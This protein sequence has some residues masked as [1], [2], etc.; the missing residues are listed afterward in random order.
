M[1]RTLRFL[2]L[3]ALPLL[4][5]SLLAQGTYWG[6]TSAG[7]TYGI[8]TI[9][10][11][12]E[13]NVYTK[14]YDFFKYDGGS[15]KGEV[16]K[17]SNGLYYGVTEF[18]GTAGV[19]VL[20]SY[21]PSTTAYTVLI[22]FSAATSPSSAAIG[23]RP[24]R[25]LRQAANG[26]LYGTCTQGGVNNLGTLFDFNIGTGV[27]TKRR[28]FDNLTTSLRSGSTPRGRLVQASNGIIYG[29]T[30]QGG[31]NGTGVIFSLSTTNTF[32]RLFDFP[33]LVPGTTGIRPFSGLMQASNGL[34]YGTTQSGGTSSGGVIYSF[35]ITG[36]VYTSVYDFV[37][38]T[39]RFPLA[40][41]VQPSNGLLYGTTTGG[42]VN[43]AGVIFSYDPVGDAY[44]DRTDL[45]SA[46]GYNPLSR[47]IVGSNGLLYGTADLGGTNSAG[48]LYSFNTASNV[49]TQVYEMAN[50]GLSDPWGGLL[51][52][53]AGTLVG[54]SNAGGVGGEG[55][56]YKYVIST[57][58][59]TELVPFSFSNGS[60]PLGR[61]LK[62]SNGLFYGLTQNGGTNNTGIL[63]SFDPTS[64]VF[65][66]LVN[67]ST[68]L[69]TY[70][71]GTMVEVS[72]KL[73]GLCSHGGTADGGTVFEYTIGGSC[74]KKQDL[75]L[76]AAGTVPLNGFFK[77]TSGKLYSTTS[78]GAANALGGL[79]DYVPGTNT[80]TPLHDFTTAD[81]SSPKGDLMQASNGS[82]YGTTSLNGQFTFGSIF[83]WNPSTSTF[84]RLYSFNSAEGAAPAGDLVQASN[85]KLYGTFSQ[86]GQGASGGIFSWNITT[87][88]YTEEYDMNIPP[89][90]TEGKASE[91]SLVQG[92]DGLLYGTCSE[93]G[94]SGTLGILFRFNPTSL[95]LTILT[96]YTGTA[97]GAS[98]FD[99]VVNETLPTSS[100]LLLNAKLFLE[101]PYDSG[102]GKMNSALRLLTG[103]NGFPTTEPFTAAGFTIVGGGGE[104][105]NASVLATTGDNA[106]V[107][108]VLVEL[109]DKN[110]SS[111]ILRTK[112]ALLQSDGDIV[113]VDNA[114]LLTFPLAVDNY[115]VAI[116][117]RNHFGVMTS[118]ATALSGSAATVDFRTGAQA[119]YGTNAQKTVGT[120]KVSWAGNVVRDHS[121]AYTGANND[122]D[123][124]LV[125]VGSTVP[126]NTVTGYY[127][128]DVTLD[129]VVSYT[130]TGNDR[131]PILVNVGGTTPNNTIAEQIP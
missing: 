58:T 105:I 46:I 55:A 11:I 48:V 78:T 122:R 93:G 95:A 112:A 2:P 73:Y 52:D 125:R 126:T 42:G 43:N 33:A 80:L 22:N 8:G 127:A 64:S 67:F 120:A 114:S 94:T 84:T 75:A 98:P 72:G 38:V 130:G 31:T 24:F 44:V 113:D 12:T 9:Y 82:L 76:T 106:V 107:D 104:T 102:T 70:P 99:G 108:W 83:S 14:K 47:M 110:N 13:A 36:S 91:S 85:G 87:S 16:I 119:T 45:S 60:A 3:I 129:G 111:T 19:G 62:S 88:T 90:T 118:T 30:Q 81:G 63:F 26:K 4:P 51:E 20:F 66:R 1:F 37:Q 53:P 96:N 109:R 131:D 65:T 117:Q 74:V 34:L 89:I 17:A 116:R 29:T 57:A 77:A 92:T 39:G 69:G 115:F 25:G 128:E 61:L 123:P 6:M 97:N 103:A 21:N 68:T 86:D 15:P 40:E 35:N 56:L 41:L 23:A 71:L 124:I 59:E 121:I 54:M 10:S 28:D 100:N 18:G 49:Y 27:L 7:G 5:T 50:N 79:F 32:T 101:G